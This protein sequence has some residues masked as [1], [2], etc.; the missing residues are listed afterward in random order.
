MHVLVMSQ[1]PNVNR[2]HI[3][4][5]K[6]QPD[7]FLSALHENVIVA[8]FRVAWCMLFDKQYDNFVYV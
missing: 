7:A 1:Y 2:Y 6:S 5:R 4:N 8:T 3:S